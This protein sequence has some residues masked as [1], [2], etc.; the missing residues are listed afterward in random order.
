V[1]DK[2]FIPWHQRYFE[3][4][5]A[6]H[7]IKAAPLTGDNNC[8][9]AG[10]CCT[11]DYIANWYGTCCYVLSNN[12]VMR[13]MEAFRIVAGHVSARCSRTQTVLELPGIESNMKRCSRKRLPGEENNAGMRGM[14][15]FIKIF[16]NQ[17]KISAT[18]NDEN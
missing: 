13:D 3:A 17:L 14:L 18:H 11:S 10:S 4:L 8:A 2:I 16:G 1:G 6:A 15:Y 7:A 9:S 5:R 12:P